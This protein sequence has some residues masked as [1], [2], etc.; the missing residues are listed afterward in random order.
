[1]PISSSASLA[2]PVPSPASE[3]RL[4]NLCSA[5][6]KVRTSTPLFWAEKRNFCK[7]SVAIPN[8]SDVFPN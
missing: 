1:M 4:V 5:M 2:T 3:I 7:S 6:S 8:R